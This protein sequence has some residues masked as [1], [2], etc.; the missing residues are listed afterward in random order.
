MITTILAKFLSFDQLSHFFDQKN[1]HSKNSHMGKFSGA[2]ENFFEE[3]YKHFLM[4]IAK[5]YDITAFIL[6]GFIKRAI[7]YPFRGSIF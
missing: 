2:Y 1:H 5:V 4:I 7:M 3:C 6:S